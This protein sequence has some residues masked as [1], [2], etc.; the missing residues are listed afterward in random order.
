MSRQRMFPEEREI[1]INRAVVVRLLL[2]Q[3]PLER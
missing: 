2:L 1:K 3:S